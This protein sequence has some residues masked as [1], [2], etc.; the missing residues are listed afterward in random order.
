MADVVVCYRAMNERSMQRFGAGVQD[1]PPLPTTESA[2]FGWYAPFGLLTPASWVAM[3]AQRYMHEYGATSE[4]FGRVSVADRKHAA[5]NPNAWFYQKPI[6]LEEH[7]QSRWIVE[8]LRLLDCCQES[9][10]AVAV[11]V[12]SVVRNLR[13]PH[14]PPATGVLPTRAA[15]RVCV[16]ELEALHAEQN[17]RAWRLADDIGEKDAIQRWEVWAREWEQRTVRDAM[18]PVTELTRIAART[19]LAEALRTMLRAEIATLPVLEGDDVIGVLEMQDIVRWIELP[20]PE[21]RIAPA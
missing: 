1:R 20:E 18:V 2:H 6:T 19:D 4:D 21:P 13:G 12:T 16:T 9:D 15:L 11:V 17:E 10:G 3:N 5:T 8:P 7:Q 14:R